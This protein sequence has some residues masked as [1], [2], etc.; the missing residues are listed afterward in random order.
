MAFRAVQL[1]L[2]ADTPTPTLVLGSGSG[3]TFKNIQGTLQDPLPVSIKNEDGT[4]VVWWGG[5]DVD[6]TNGQ[7]IAPGGTIVMNLYNPSEIPYV[8]STGTPIVSV[9][10]GR[11]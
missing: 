8:W 3:T 1:T 4:A 11:Q 10:C 9:T 7:S 5:S 6:S 2:T